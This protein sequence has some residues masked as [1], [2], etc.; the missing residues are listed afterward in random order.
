LCP[1]KE[2]KMLMLTHPLA[3]ERERERAKVSF[4]NKGMGRSHETT[5]RCF[6]KKG[7]KDVEYIYPALKCVLTLPSLLEIFGLGKSAQQMRWAIKL[8][9]NE[10]SSILLHP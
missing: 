8:N 7:R 4:Y 2:R 10:N 1:R 9:N 3:R 5:T 6:T